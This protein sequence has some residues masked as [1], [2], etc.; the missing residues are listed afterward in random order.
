MSE[1]KKEVS[2]NF[3]I[4]DQII[5][6]SIEELWE[7]LE[8]LYIKTYP[9]GITEENITDA[10]NDFARGFPNPDFITTL[11]TS[12][13]GIIGR[14]VSSEEEEL[15]IYFELNREY[16]DTGKLFLAK[17][18]TKT[19]HFTCLAP[20]VFKALMIFRPL[21]DTLQ[22]KYLLLTGVKAVHMEINR[23]V[24]RGLSFA[25]QRAYRAWKEE[26]LKEFLGTF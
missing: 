11:F 7:E 16:I 6:D 2:I 22:N 24:N 15:P 10:M 26:G 5:Q 17:Y 25:I 14:Y 4:T 13:T 23:R 12:C 20:C 18:N 3:I 9:I 8:M 21:Y 19:L 1:I